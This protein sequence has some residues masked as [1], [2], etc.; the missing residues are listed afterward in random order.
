MDF[1]SMFESDPY[2][3]SIG[4]QEPYRPADFDIPSID[5]IYL[6]N[7]E[8]TNAFKWL[9]Q[10]INNLMSVTK[11][12]PD[13][14]NKMFGGVEIKDEDFTQFGRA[15]IKLSE[16]HSMVTE[17]MGKPW[18]QKRGFDDSF[19]GYTHPIT[20]G[21]D[22]WWGSGSGYAGSKNINFNASASDENFFTDKKNKNRGDI[23]DSW[24]DNSGLFKKYFNTD[25]DQNFGSYTQYLPEVENLLKGRFGGMNYYEIVMSGM[26]GTNIK[27][28]TGSDGGK[29]IIYNQ[30]QWGSF[31]YDGMSD[32]N[33]FY[34]MVAMTRD[35]RKF[36]GEMSDLFGMIKNIANGDNGP[37]DKE[38]IDTIDSW[39]GNEGKKLNSNNLGFLS[40]F[41]QGLQ[42][43]AHFV[44]PAFSGTARYQF[45]DITSE[46]HD[47]WGAVK[48][49]SNLGD[50]GFCGKFRDAQD[51]VAFKRFR[52]LIRTNAM[53]YIDSI[54]DEDE[55]EN[56]L[57]LYKEFAYDGYDLPYGQG[58]G[59]SR[60]IGWDAYSS[61]TSYDNDLT[62][63]MN[64]YATGLLGGEAA[65]HPFYSIA[66]VLKLTSNQMR[67]KELVG[68]K[69]LFKNNWV[70]HMLAKFS[71][72]QE[73]GKLEPVVV[74]SI[75]YSNYVRYGEDQTDFRNKKKE[76]K[77]K[78][79]D[80][81]RLDSISESKAYQRKK[82]L[83][84]ISEN[85]AKKTEQYNN[86]MGQKSEERKRSERIDSQK[87]VERVS[88]QKRILGNRKQQPQKKK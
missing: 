44:L 39:I 68:G 61:S 11:F 48:D 30:T 76:I 4:L 42:H 65:T 20:A 74:S 10:K 25:D 75:N 29:T 16:L 19:F 64:P 73:K 12:T 7:G 27:Y 82:E 66:Q 83:Q 54:D 52:Q 5:E 57:K 59:A 70:V 38:M 28:G 50:D 26:N 81:K 84:K 72:A 2:G 15:S 47:D 13:Y 88:D 62:P 45:N 37:K 86:L 41:T 23:V 36:F 31:K 49:W 46:N 67:G 78:I 34:L 87:R 69:N 51:V 14:M 17:G 56:A 71:E 32:Q 9:C 40:M 55:K 80:Q 35:R 53:D 22:Q 77:E 79:A 1:G 63:N 43:Y 24:V 3:Y 33:W 8:N 18:E 60:N 58:D 21:F 85:N 6:H